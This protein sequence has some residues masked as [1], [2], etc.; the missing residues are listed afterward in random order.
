MG[1][2]TS[3]KGD[4]DMAENEAVEREPNEEEVETAETD[5]EGHSIGEEVGNDGQAFLNINF[6]CEKP[7]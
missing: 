6:G 5:V 2:V 3:R 1:W 7:S 4:E